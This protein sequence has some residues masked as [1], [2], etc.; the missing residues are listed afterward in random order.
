MTLNND[1]KHI[2]NWANDW[3]VNFNLSKT[4]SMLTSRKRDPVNYPPLFMNNIPLKCTSMHKHL[5][6]T[7]SDT[8]DWTN[9]ITNITNAAWARLN[10]LRTLKFKINRRALEK[11]Y[12]AFIRPVLEYS[13]SV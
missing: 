1:L 11:I 2:S 13:D 10:L 12:S 7:F 3:L 4:F 9:H 8:C 5:G 6:L